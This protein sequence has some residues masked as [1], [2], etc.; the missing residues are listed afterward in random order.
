MDWSERHYSSPGSGQALLLN[1]VESDDSIDPDAAAGI[2][3][4]SK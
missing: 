2:L 4:R 1:V 3:H